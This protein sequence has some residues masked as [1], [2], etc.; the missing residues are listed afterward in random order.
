MCFE[1]SPPGG[2][3]THGKAGAIELAARGSSPGGLAARYAAALFELADEKRQLDAVASDLRDLQAIIA[4]SED[5][6]RLIRSPV[7]GREEQA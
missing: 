5:L 7:L 3:R 4:Q 2:N 1:R 6:R